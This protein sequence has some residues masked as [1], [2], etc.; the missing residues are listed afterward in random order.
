MDVTSISS[1]CFEVIFATCLIDLVERKAKYFF[2][3]SGVQLDQF[4]SRRQEVPQKIAE[5]K[6]S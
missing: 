1:G 5:R 3:P 4:S 6:I 2:E